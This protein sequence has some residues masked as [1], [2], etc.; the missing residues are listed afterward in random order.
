MRLSIAGANCERESLSLLTED[1]YRVSR[2][3]S[4]SRF[5]MSSCLDEPRTKD[6]LSVL[7]SPDFR[8][9]D[10]LG[11]SE[12]YVGLALSILSPDFSLYDVDFSQRPEGRL[13]VA[14]DVLRSKGPE[15]APLP[16]RLYLLGLENG[17]VLPLENLLPR[18]N[19]SSGSFP[20][21][22]SRLPGL[23]S[24][25]SDRLVLRE[26]LG[27]RLSLTTLFPIRILMEEFSIL[28]DLRD[29]RAGFLSGSLGV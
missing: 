21:S 4:C 28:P 17:L 16:R 6:S 29:S 25:S 3:T 22:E 11:D 12:G 20:V 18:V 14:C 24:G 13:S 10:D 23:L 5:L 19:D 27:S 8:E 15:G 7:E 1:G 26:R 2:S 9:Y